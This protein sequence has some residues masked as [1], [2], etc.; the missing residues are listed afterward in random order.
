M[1]MRLA[2]NADVAFIRGADQAFYRLHEQNMRKSFSTL[3]DL[4]ERRLAFETVLDRY[5]ERLPGAQRRSGCLYRALARQAIWAAGR[6]YDRGETP[7]A[8]VDELMA[9]AVDCWPGVSRLPLYRILESRKRIGPRGMQY[10]LDQKA[11]S[12]LRRQSWKYRGV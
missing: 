5:G 9:F 8:S 10:M 11:R 3:M 6:A 7:Q 4:R 1:W 12:W 2:A